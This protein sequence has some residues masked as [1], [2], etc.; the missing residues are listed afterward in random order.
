ML[1]LF[2]IARLRAAQDDIIRS[3]LEQD[4]TLATLPTG[5]GKS[6]CYPHHQLFPRPGFT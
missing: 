1:D 6:L 2:G 4:V 5:A 3:V